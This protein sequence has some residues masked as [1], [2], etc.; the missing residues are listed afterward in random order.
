MSLLKRRGLR[1]KI[2]LLLTLKFKWLFR[3]SIL[4]LK[5]SFLEKLIE[6][7]KAIYS[8]MQK[9]AAPFEI[10]AFYEQEAKDWGDIDTEIKE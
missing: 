3:A 6:E 2:I 4:N 7:V 5:T 8:E 9:Q 10:N 1:I